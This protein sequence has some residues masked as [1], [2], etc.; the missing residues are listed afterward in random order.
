MSIYNSVADSPN[1]NI[2]EKL[3]REAEVNYVHMRSK[4]SEWLKFLIRRRENTFDNVVAANNT[5][6]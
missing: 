1:Q 6:M 2:E 3:G 5:M 4:R